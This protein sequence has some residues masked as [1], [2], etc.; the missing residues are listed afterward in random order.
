MMLSSTYIL[1]RAMTNMEGPGGNSNF[2]TEAGNRPSSWFNLWLDWGHQFQVP[3]QRWVT[4]FDYTSP[5]GKGEAWGDKVPA[6]GQRCW[7]AGSCSR[8][9]PSPPGITRR[10]TLSGTPRALNRR[11]RTGRTWCPVRTQQ[12]PQNGSRLVQ[13]RRLHHPNRNSHHHRPRLSSW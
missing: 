7:E 6:A 5:F 12:R 3:T 2:T 13:Y 4:N 10:R 8:L 1:S 11:N 9:S